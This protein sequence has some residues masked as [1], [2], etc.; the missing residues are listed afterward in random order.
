MC[1][2]VQLQ[3]HCVMVKSEA[4]GEQVLPQHHRETHLPLSAGLRSAFSILHLTLTTMGQCYEVKPTPTP[5]C[6]GSRMTSTEAAVFMG[7]GMW[8]EQGH[9][10]Y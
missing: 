2:W 3:K 10:G 8:R 5:S 9:G 6:S 1:S 4:R 7:G